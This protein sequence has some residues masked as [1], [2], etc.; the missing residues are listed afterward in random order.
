LECNCSHEKLVGMDI[1]Q[2]IKQAREERGWSMER[3]AKE[4]SEA[5]GLQKPLTW[6][7]VQQWENGASAP[8]RTRMEVVRRLLSLEAPPA[9]GDVFEQLT[10]AE[11]SMLQNYRRLLDKDRKQF[12]ADIQA[13]AEERQAEADELFARFGVARAAD[14]AHARKSRDTI[15]VAVSGAPREDDLFDKGSKE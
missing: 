15:N 9:K 10:P 13:R 14:R 7:T 5:E 3:L 6:Q 8:K 4:I 2:Q 1:H 11:R 12:D